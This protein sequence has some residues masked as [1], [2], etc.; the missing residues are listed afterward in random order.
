MSKKRFK[1]SDF[2]QS[3]RK[4]LGGD[5]KIVYVEDSTN[6]F[7]CSEKCIRAY[8]DPMAEHY[9]Q[10]MMEIRDPHDISEADFADFE[11]YAPLC[12]SNP[13][14]EWVDATEFGETITYFLANYTN[15]GGKFTYIVACF[16]LEDEPTYILLSFPTREKKLAEEFRRGEKMERKDDDDEERPEPEVSPVLTEDFLARQ[17][18]AIEEE[19]LRHRE[20]ADIPQT[21]F[22]E[23]T[24]LVDQ[25]I[26]SPD[27]V[28]ELDD[29]GDNPL[30]T[31]ISQFEESLHYLVICTSENSQGQESWRVIYSFPT[32]D[33]RARAALPA[34][35]LARGRGGRQGQL[36]TLKIGKDRG[37]GRAT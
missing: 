8:Y 29:E 32:R 2:C 21:E 4:T 1:Y 16:C 10:A 20:A 7:F 26:E 36:F 25:T 31:L 13:D 11:S 17:G 6:R 9:R 37:L 30:L 34:R 12:L 33:P 24:H 35:S 27:E 15:E 5:E 23:Y 19:M 14:E 18:N 22:K 28:W 3:C